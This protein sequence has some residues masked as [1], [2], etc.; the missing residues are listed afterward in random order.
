MPRRQ[1]IPSPTR[2][3]ESDLLYADDYKQWLKRTK[4]SA[5][6][7]LLPP[8]NALCLH[9]DNYERARSDEYLARVR[10]DVDLDLLV[11]IPGRRQSTLPLPARF[12]R[13]TPAHSVFWISAQSFA[14]IYECIVAG[15]WSKVELMDA[16]FS[17]QSNK[18]QLCLTFS[19]Q[20][21]TIYNLNP[22]QPP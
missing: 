13:I 11:R 15:R 17:Y 12:F 3:T 16:V 6:A 19:H 21:S 1:N 18:A 5:A 7:R 2:L 20:A 9:D 14:T 8:S 10:L 22:S 4:A